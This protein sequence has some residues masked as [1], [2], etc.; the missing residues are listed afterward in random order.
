MNSA[1]L[2]DLAVPGKI[3]TEKVQ[4]MMECETVM[5]TDA[6][7]SSAEVSG[8]KE[9]EKPSLLAAATVGTRG[10]VCPLCKKEVKKDL[11]EHI[12]R[13]HLSKD[14]VMCELCG[15]TMTKHRL[16]NHIM[17]VHEQ[18]RDKICDICGFKSYSNPELKLHIQ[19]VHEGVKKERKWPCPY[20]EYVARSKIIR[21]NHVK[22]VHEKTRDMRC[23]LCEEIFVTIN[24]LNKH[25]RDFHL[26][27][28]RDRCA[29]CGFVGNTARELISHLRD[30]EKY[31]LIL[32][33]TYFWNL[34]PTCDNIICTPAHGI[35]KTCPKCGFVEKKVRSRTID[36][37]TN[38]YARI[39][40][41]SIL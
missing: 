9:E 33:H 35:R 36:M 14:D 38:G 21:D 39:N 19:R 16:Q 5:A 1:Y 29:E 12:K 40:M 30:G 11:K 37:P 4:S 10:G 13:V 7:S 17:H 23:P 22:A 2:G 31:R 8:I 27:L 32:L 24:H 3:K 15:K 41:R 26:D 18:I 20:C 28:Q 6:P 25:I 34:I